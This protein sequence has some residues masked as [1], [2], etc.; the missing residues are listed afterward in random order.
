MGQTV[1][2]APLLPESLPFLNLPRSTILE[3]W[4]SY[5]D[6]AEGFGLTLD[7]FQEI[8]RVTLKDYLGYSD[9][10]MNSLAEAVF[11]IYDDDENGLID[12]LEFLS[13][14]ALV[15]GMS[16]PEK[17]RFIFGIYD[18]DE[19]GLLSVDEATLSL[20]SCM[21]GLT[22]L[23]GIDPPPEAA[24]EALAVSAFEDAPVAGAEANM[25]ARD[26]FVDYAKR[27]PEVASWM[28]YY[29]ELAEVEVEAFGGEKFSK[30][31]VTREAVALERGDADVA[32]MDTDA[33]T[34]AWLSVEAKGYAENFVPQQPWQNTVSFTEPSSLPKDIPSSAPDT[35]LSLDWVH[36]FNS[37]ESRNNV[38]YTRSGDSI[39][40]PAGSV[41][42]KMSELGGD[43]P[44]QVKDLSFF[45]ISLILLH[46]SFLFSSPLNI[47][48]SSPFLLP[49]SPILLLPLP[50]PLPLALFFRFPLF[51]F[52][53]FFC[54]F[55][56][57]FSFFFFFFSLLSRPTRT[58]TPTRSLHSPFTT[59]PRRSRMSP[60]GR[61][62]SIPRSTSGPATRWRLPSF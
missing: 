11:N 55:F 13:S 29:G 30:A 45:L 27:T 57:F 33:G 2:R 47:V 12:A 52:F 20:R 56:S 31:L 37:R 51:R 61:S 62:A 1:G 10:K 25:I 41:G 39:L 58:T 23:S 53:C 4:E 32:S 42:V 14:F 18:F 60:L 49:L 7:E 59:S 43:S 44:T 28:C 8:V 38:F 40:Y 5:N 50:S 34:A 26:K 9:K 22:K 35:N 6:I 3:L 19:S 21:S 15:S 17:V 36:G 54:F 24:L 16:I 48:L 46:S